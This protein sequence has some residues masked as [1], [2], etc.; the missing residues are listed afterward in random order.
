MLS[1]KT[2]GLQKFVGILTTLI[3]AA[4]SSVEQIQPRWFR[5]QF[6]ITAA[7]SSAKQIQPGWFYV[8]QPQDYHTESIK[9]F[10]LRDR[11]DVLLEKR[12]D[13]VA[14]Q[15]FAQLYGKSRIRSLTMKHRFLIIPVLI[16]LT[17]L[18]CSGLHEKNANLK[19]LGHIGLEALPVTEV[20]FYSESVE[21]DMVINVVLPRGYEQ[22]DLRYP[23]LYLCHGL[24]SNYNEFKYVGVPEYLNRFD[25]IVVMVDVG[26]SWY[27]NWAQSDNNQHN[28]FVISNIFYLLNISVLFYPF[29]VSFSHQLILLAIHNLKTCVF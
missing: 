18:G 23:V 8:L 5:S 27:V 6:C 14:E 19:A 15:G 17:I 12:L 20:K 25:M 29:F 3:T 2:H 7:K 24:T 21:R 9:K 28:N 4:S 16:L 10:V 11:F 26:N 13:G 1:V 22:S